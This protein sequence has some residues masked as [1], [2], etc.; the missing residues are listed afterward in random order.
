MALPL[1]RFQ[2][3]AAIADPEALWGGFVG[4]LSRLYPG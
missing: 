3:F 4:K 2:S 1:L